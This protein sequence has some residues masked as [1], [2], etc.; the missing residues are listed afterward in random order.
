[1][2]QAD[3]PLT[4]V[5]RACTARVD[6]PLQGAIDSGATDPVIVAP[7]EIDEVV[8]AEMPFLSQED[9]DNL[10]PLAGALA[11]GRLEPTE[12]WNSVQRYLPNL[13]L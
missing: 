2:L 12:I 8:S 13:C 3:T 11:T 5:E 4:E 6:H 10:L 9:V 7:Y 1:M